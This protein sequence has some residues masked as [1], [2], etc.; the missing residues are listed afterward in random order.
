[1]GSDGKSLHGHLEG[2]TGMLAAPGAPAQPER[3]FLLAICIHAPGKVQDVW[4]IYN[5]PHLF[6]LKRAIQ[7]GVMPAFGAQVGSVERRL[8]REGIGSELHRR[9]SAQPWEAL[10]TQVPLLK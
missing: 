10:S 8:R 9:G 7:E 4:L 5:P 3:G 1:M 2:H 6:S